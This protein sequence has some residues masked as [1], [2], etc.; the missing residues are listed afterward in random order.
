MTMD[1]LNGASYPQPYEDFV[2]TINMRKAMDTFAV[3]LTVIHTWE[4]ASWRSLYSSHESDPSDPISL[5]EKL[6]LGSSHWCGTTYCYAGLHAQLSDKVEFIVP[7]PEDVSASRLSAPYYSSAVVVIS[8]PTGL[9]SSIGID[10]QRERIDG[11]TTHTGKKITKDTVVQHIDVWAYRDLG[12]QEFSSTFSASNSLEELLLNLLAE[13]AGCQTVGEED[14]LPADELVEDKN[15]SAAVLVW[16]PGLIEV[17]EWALEHYRDTPGSNQVASESMDLLDEHISIFTRMVSSAR[18]Q[19][20][21]ENVYTPVQ[22]A[23]P[24]M[25]MAQRPSQ[26]SVTH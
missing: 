20:H 6:A 17:M 15:F 2:P 12:L 25:S 9:E 10:S 18:W 4:Q 8:D 1:N 22:Y 19:L 11:K 23:P 14:V 24:L 7:A 26:E 13:C 21:G 5:D 3:L 16:V